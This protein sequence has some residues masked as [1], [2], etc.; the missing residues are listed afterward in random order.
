M[1]GLQF[2]YTE[3][4]FGPSLSHLTSYSVTN[5]EPLENHKSTFNK[6]KGLSSSLQETLLRNRSHLFN[7]TANHTSGKFLQCGPEFC[8]T[9]TAAMFI[10]GDI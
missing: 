6:S 3:A 5:V 10:T 1:C 4:Y 9:I 2:L 8:T 7:Y